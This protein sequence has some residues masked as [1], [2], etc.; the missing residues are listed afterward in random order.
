MKKILILSAAFLIFCQTAALCQQGSDPVTGAISNLKTLLTD[1]MEE[2]A[3]LQFDHPYPYYVAGEVI[4]FKAYV[5]MGELRQ[6]SGLSGVLHVD[7]IDPQNVVLKS[8]AL[9]LNGGTGF[10]DLGLPDTLQKGS[11]RVR[12]YTQWMRNSKNPYFFD[13]FISVSAVNGVDRSSYNTVQAQKPD[14]QFFPEGGNLVID[15]PS[16]VAFKAIGT[17][18]LGITVKG[19]VVD[20]EN[21]E[22]AAIN[23]SHLGMGIFRFIPEEGKTYSAK[24]SFG[25]GAQSSI[26]LPQAEA[27]GIILSVNT[28]DSSKLS[29]TIRANHLY[30]KDNQNKQLNLLIYYAGSVKRYTPKL[31]HA[32]LLLD[33]PAS[34]FPTGIVK[35]TLL[36]ESGEPLDERLTF[37]QNKDLLNLSV[38]AYKTAFSPR[39]NV[40]LNLTAKDKNGAPVNG[41]FSVS[42]IDES[43]LLVDEDADNTILSYFLLTSEIK[44]YIEKPNYY[45]TN[46]TDQTRADLDILMMTQG[47]RRFSWKELMGSPVAQANAYNPERGMNI[48]GVLKTKSGEPVANCSL[49]LVPVSGGAP[50]TGTTDSQGRFIFANVPFWG[51]SKFI[52]NAL[53]ASGKK[54]VLTLDN[55]VS[56]PSLTPG[57]PL[58]VKYNANADILASLQNSQGQGPFLASSVSEKLAINNEKATP[59]N[60]RFQYRSSNLGGPGHADAVVLGDKLKNSTSLSIGL[61]GLLPGVAFNA[62]AP[63]LQTSVVVSNGSQN[64][65]TMLVVV[66]GVE[67]GSGVNID[68][69]NPTTVEAVELLRGPNAS[70]YGVSG[71]AGVMVITTRI[72]NRSDEPVSQQMSPGIFSIEPNGFYKAREFYSPKYDTGKPAGNI[73]DRRTTIYWQP[74]LVTDVS[75]NAS[76]NFFN[77]DA[78][79]TYRVE[80][81]G[82]DSKGNLGRQVFRYKVQ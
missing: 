25:N 58:E 75:G 11:Y 29:I 18:G 1:H 56:E 23:S 44:G 5:T 82:M 38:S 31:D 8:I 17:N 34:A 32:A 47:Y 68:L 35:I 2:K 49:T 28:N 10:G 19:V 65:E 81:E 40:A 74:D 30:Y 61:S 33:L 50:V 63:Y 3:Y 55:N 16:R 13:Q 52:L 73:P 41:S 27:K 21:K 53:S 14:L 20:N 70:I 42:V 67:L 71:G 36:S 15:L 4:Y 45:F 12:A 60:T 26:A 24:V 43:K 77:S 46:V 7:L 80:V 79:G 64:V 51:G 39:E 48:S 57:N 72:D 22:V 78:K 59:A 9:P 37:I 66:D 62:G 6:P 54:S 69:V 76:F